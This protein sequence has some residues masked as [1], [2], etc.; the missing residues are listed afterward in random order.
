MKN[1]ESGIPAGAIGTG[2]E[3][4]IVEVRF[5]HAGGVLSA[6][7]V[8]INYGPAGGTGQMGIGGLRFDSPSCEV[9]QRSRILRTRGV[10]LGSL[11]EHMSVVIV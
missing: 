8:Q 6:A 4:R 2:A 1:S 5:D 7:C 11:K 9:L 10:K 3:L